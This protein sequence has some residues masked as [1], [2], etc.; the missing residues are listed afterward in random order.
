MEQLPIIEM[1]EIGKYI[2]TSDHYQHVFSVSDVDASLI[3]DNTVN[4]EYTEPV[5]LNA[6]FMLLVLEGTAHVRLDFVSYTLTPNMFL[7]IMPTHIFQIAEAGKNFKARLIV[8]DRNFLEGINTEKR[9]PAMSNYLLLRKNPCTEF[10]PEEAKYVHRSI[11]VLRDKIRMRN[12]SFHKE[13]LQNAF[14]GFMLE[15]AN[16]MIGKSDQ[17]VRPTLTRKEELFN[18]FLQL[19]IKNVKQE[20]HVSYYAAQLFITPQYLSLILKELSGKSANKWIDEAL[21]VEA[22]ILLKSPQMT[23]QQVADE[24]NFSDQST[25]GK[26]FKKQVGLSP[27]EYRRS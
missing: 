20:H 15:L 3:T 24:L 7:T 21:L 22:K 26:F 6:L 5:R 4:K 8:L 13:V 14:V 18:F 10:S 1:A 11:G 9:S 12:H 19:L 17:L 2:T 27:M 16:L 23:I 25:F